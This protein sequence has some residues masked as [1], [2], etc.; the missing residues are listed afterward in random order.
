MN[1]SL[2]KRLLPLRSRGE[3][4]LH[5]NIVVVIVASA[6][7]IHADCANQEKEDFWEPMGEVM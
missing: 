1:Q 2:S 3:I 5:V 6:Q 4:D 7:A